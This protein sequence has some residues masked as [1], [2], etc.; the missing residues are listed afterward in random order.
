MQDARCSGD[1]G[2]PID[3][4][5]N[6]RILLAIA[7]EGLTSARMLQPVVGRLLPAMDFQVGGCHWAEPEQLDWLPW[8]LSER[9]AKTG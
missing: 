1:K 2:K 3:E 8:I 4:D 6:S 7:A 5:L 9:Q